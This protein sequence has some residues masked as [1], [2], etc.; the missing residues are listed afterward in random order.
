MTENASA[1]ETVDAAFR[2]HTTLGSG[3]LESVYDTV[4]AYEL[5]R[6]QLA[7]F[8][9]NGDHGLAES[10]QFAFGFRFCKFDH[11][12]ARHR[13]ADGGRVTAI[14]DQALGDVIYR[15]ATGFLP[16]TRIHD[17]LVRHPS[18]G[19]PKPVPP[20]A[21]SMGSMKILTQIVAGRELLRLDTPPTAIMVSNSKLL[22]GLIQALDEKK[23]RIPA[24]GW[25]SIGSRVSSPFYI[26]VT[27]S[28]PTL[29]ER[30]GHT[31]VRCKADFGQ[32][33]ARV[34]G[35]AKQQVRTSGPHRIPGRLAGEL[36][37]R[38]KAFRFSCR[39]GH[40]VYGPRP[41]W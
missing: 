7:S 33:A 25:T 40:A 5:G 28:F 14:I 6:L 8:C 41:R 21:S 31:K 12:R 26:R 32:Q 29:L 15:Y 4:L 34:N 39:E 11:E 10:V 30:T 20:P 23:I 35:C 27:M 18:L 19:R 17:A 24:G 37:N 9:A 16:R 1:K 38:E 22:L 13:K 2:I 3:P 36:R